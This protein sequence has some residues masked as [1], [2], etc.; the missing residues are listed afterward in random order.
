[1]RIKDE[2]SYALV[3]GGIDLKEYI[4]EFIYLF[5]E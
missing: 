1:M 3:H 5:F 2:E 4:K